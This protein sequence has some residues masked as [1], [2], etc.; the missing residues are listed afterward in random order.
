MSE[1]PCQDYD[2]PYDDH[3]DDCVDD[4]PD[5]WKFECAAYWT[6]TDWH[7]P[8]AGTEDCDWECTEIFDDEE[9]R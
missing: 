9:P 6:G 2:G 3:I 5:E 4:D 8:L 7:C 1:E